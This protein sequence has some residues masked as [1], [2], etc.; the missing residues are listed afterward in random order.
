LFVGWFVS[1]I[2]L[3]FVGFPSLP[4]DERRAR[5]ESLDLTRVTVAPAD[6]LKIAALPAIEDVR[7]LSVDGQPTYVVLGGDKA[8]AVAGDAGGLIPARDEAAAKRI[9]QRFGGAKA[10]RVAGPFDYDQ[11]IVHQQFDRA[12]PFFRVRLDD[13]DATDLYVSA[14]TGEVLQRT[15]GSERAWNWCGAVLHWI[16]FTPIRKDWSLWN[17]L[18]WWV[19]LVALVTSVIGVWLGVIRTIAVRGIRREA[20]TP[21]RGWLRWHHVIG[22]AASV[23]VVIWIYSGWL[24]M[25]HGRLFSRGEIGAQQ[26]D[27][28]RGMSL[29]DVAEQ[30]SLE[31]VRSIGSASE[32]SLGAVNARGFL[33]VRTPDGPARTQWLA[34][35][36][37]SAPPLPDDLLLSALR[38]AWDQV[39]LLSGDTGIDKTYRLAESLPEDALVAQ[40]GP[41]TNS[42]RVYVDRTSGRLLAVMDSSRRAYAWTY[43]ALHTLN[44]PGLNALPSLRTVTIVLLMLIGLTFSVTGVIVGVR[45]LRLQFR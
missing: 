23:V 26:I 15:R 31:R 22:L 11:W 39:E 29:A 32:I 9:A 14:R 5:S 2:V 20:W 40:V 24:S 19:S 44:F 45:R 25:D 17:Q 33:T 8:V 28:V 3:H 4:V 27:A 30:A 13:A 16:Y 12:R 42:S 36:E 37:I 35:G 6:A 7:L 41:A 43:Y 18:V 21:F 10:E 1:G 34:T 38:R